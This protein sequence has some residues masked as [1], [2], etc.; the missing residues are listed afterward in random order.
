VSEKVAKSDSFISFH[1]CNLN[2]L[3][4]IN[5]TGTMA[6]TAEVTTR[7]ASIEPYYSHGLRKRYHLDAYKL[8]VFENAQVYA[9]IE[10]KADNAK[11]HARSAARVRAGGLESDVP[12]GWPKVLNGPLV[13]TT[14]DLKG[15]AEFV[16]T[17]FD[18]EKAEI[19]DALKVFRGTS[20][21]P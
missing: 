2:R 13:W 12:F 11:Y 15:E 1:T 3:T 6:P 7:N 20:P 4:H 9:D 17:L 8:P 14:A 16:H 19:V 10:Y 5:L 21:C 18:A